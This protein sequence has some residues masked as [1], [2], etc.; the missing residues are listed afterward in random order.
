M[1]RALADDRTIR[2]PSTASRQLAA[3]RHAES[4][5]ARSGHAAPSG[6]E[7]ARRTG[8]RRRRVDAL[9][10]AAHVTA[11]LDAT[12]GGAQTALGDLVASEGDASTALWRCVDARQ[13]R[14]RVL[15]LL[16]VLPARHREVLERRFGL[17]GRPVQT[18]REIAPGLGVGEERSRQIEHQA[19]HWLRTLMA[20]SPQLAA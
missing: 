2:I 3:I 13:D 4:E 16:Q 7:L 15:K 17:A 8:L 9:R 19:L 18:H 6:E 1:L 5:L 12:V 10:L 14:E 11:S 20:R